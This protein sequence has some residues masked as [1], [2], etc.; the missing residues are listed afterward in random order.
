MY[1][2]KNTRSVREATEKTKTGLKHKA[3]AG[4]YGRKDDEEDTD[5]DG[6]KIKKVTKDEPKK[7]RGRPKK[8][9][10]A[11]GE[12]TKFDTSELNNLFGGKKPK[13]DKWDKKK[14]T[15]VTKMKDGDKNDKEELD[16]EK[17]TG[18]NKKFA[19]LAKPKDK[20]TFADKIAGAKKKKD[21]QMES[22]DKQLKTLLSEGLTVST[23]VG[24]QGGQDTVSITASDTDAHQL[25]QMLQNAG[26]GSGVPHHAV[27]AAAAPATVLP[28]DVSSSPALSAASSG[29]AT[30]DNVETPGTNVSS[31]P[32]PRG[33]AFSVQPEETEA[34][35]A[36]E[37]FGT[38]DQEEVVSALGSEQ[39]SADDSGDSALAA[40]KKLMGAHGASEVSA[41][42]ATPPESKAPA[43]ETETEV[44]ESDED[45][46]KPDED[47]DGVP[48][49]ADKNEGEDY[50]EDDS[51]ESDDEDK[52]KVEEGAQTCNE[53]GGLM[54]DDHQCGQ[55]NEWSNSP[56]GQS[57]DE[58]FDTDMKFMQDVIT[59]GLN[60]R[61]ST[62]QATTPVLASQTN[63]QMSEGYNIDVA[64]EMRKLAGIR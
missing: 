56:D 30:D 23:S 4:G 29:S 9:D 2:S 10:N 41:Q 5:E 49:W 12:D 28:K 52:E 19:A 58:Q 32:M 63:R 46:K 35:S 36:P 57:K 51:E 64:A 8:T 14:T 39:S 13:S 18:K 24:N 16:E 20:I 3:D 21:V 53:C 11:S 27:Q 37:E 44:E 38:L 22:W 1:E 40:I 54:E 15:K 47:D 33:M 26:M 42:E 62:G 31:M 17:L 48:D 7:G 6:K 60:G 55:L 45:G 34:P 43:T 59:A 50:R 61:K 25:L